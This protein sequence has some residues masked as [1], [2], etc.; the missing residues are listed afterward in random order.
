MDR[1]HLED[2]VKNAAAA[3]SALNDAVAR[4]MYNARIQAVQK[5]NELLY[6][7]AEEKCVSIYEICANTIPVFEDTMETSRID[8]GC[9]V[10]MK[11]VIKL[12]PRK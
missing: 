6:K 10:T 11:T 4:G 1:N 3:E 7:T 8:G 9:N 2:L 5:L 12:V